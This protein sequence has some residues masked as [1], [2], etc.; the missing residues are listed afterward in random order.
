MPM[1]TGSDGVRQSAQTTRLTTPV[2]TTVAMVAIVAA[3]SPAESLRVSS[4]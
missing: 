2:P 1:S 3:S 4:E